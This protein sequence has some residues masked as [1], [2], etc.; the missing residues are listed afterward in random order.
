MNKALLNIRVRKLHHWF[1][2][3][4]GAQ[5]GL[6][7]ISGLFMTLFPIE[8]VRGDHLK[9]SSEPVSISSQTDF[10]PLNTII[11]SGYDDAV[12]GVQLKVVD[13][14]TSWIISTKNG[15]NLLINAQTGDVLSPLTEDIAKRIA[16]GIYIGKGEIVLAELL[17]AP[18]REYGRPGPVWRVDYS[19]P[20]AATFYV[21]ATTGDVKAVRTGLW[22]TF[23]FMW[24]LHIMDWSNRENF[25]SWWI[26]MT[27]SL[28]VLFFISGLIL[29]FLKT[30]LMFRQRRRSG[31]KAEQQAGISNVDKVKK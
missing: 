21:D 2:I 26:K 18:P 3:L 24:G 12:I 23:D 16:N 22:R 9:A 30:G 5:L 8:Q 13:G 29:V 6:W 7:L 11:L 14:Q 31:P 25:N 20:Q 4:I 19:K 27:A 28:A 17:D 10:L 15:K 1:G